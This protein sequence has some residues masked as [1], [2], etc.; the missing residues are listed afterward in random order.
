ML[1]YYEDCRVGMQVKLSKP[2]PTYV[3]A[4]SNPAVG[5]E[6]ECVGTICEVDKYEKTG[7]IVE[8]EN[9]RTNSYKA[10]ELSLV[11]GIGV[12]LSIW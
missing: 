12:C 4:Q 2:D 3:L 11:D 9:G 10:G 7:I 5:T 6:W 8:W 1:L